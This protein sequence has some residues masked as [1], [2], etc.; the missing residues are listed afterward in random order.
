[1]LVE[2]KVGD[3]GEAGQLGGDG[4][5]DKRLVE[6]EVFHRSQSGNGSGWNR[7]ADMVVPERQRFECSETL[8]STGSAPLMPLR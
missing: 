8:N 2:R 7:A 1:M 5:R 6:E 3:I 4:A